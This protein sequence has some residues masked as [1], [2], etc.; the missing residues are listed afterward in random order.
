MH[1]LELYG[2]IVEGDLHLFEIFLLIFFCSDFAAQKDEENDADD[3]IDVDDEVE[4]VIA[5]G[6]NLADVV[7]VVVALVN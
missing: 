7:G 1:S 6:T 5:C 3:E 4:K 2:K